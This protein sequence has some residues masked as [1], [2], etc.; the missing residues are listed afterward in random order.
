[1]F[2]LYFWYSSILTEEIHYACVST[3]QITTAVSIRL[4]SEPLVRVSDQK[5]IFIFTVW[6]LKRSEGDNSCEHQKQMLNRLI[7]K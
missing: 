7:R 3:D 4:K 2:C 6:V 1:M 5:L